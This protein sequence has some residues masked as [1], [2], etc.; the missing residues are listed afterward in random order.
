MVAGWWALWEVE[1]RSSTVLRI[2]HQYL[3]SFG[4]EFADA[5]LFLAPPV[6]V[7]GIVHML[8]Y[9][10]DRRI[11]GQRWTLRDIL[12]LTTWS[13]ASP[14]LALL[15]IAIGFAGV[16]DSRW[17]GVLWLIVGGVSAVVGTVG[18]RSAEGLKFRRV[19]SGELYKR[20]FFV[21]KE[22][23]IPLK[24]VYIVP[25]GRGQLMNAYGLSKSIAVT[26]NYGKFLRGA[27]LDFVIG[28]ELAHVKERNAWGNLMLM[29]AIFAALLLGVVL[30]SP[31]PSWLRPWLDFIII[32][33]P[34]LTFY[35][36]SRRSEYAA[37]RFAVELTH[38]P[39]AGIQA[40]C[41]LYRV[42]LAPA[43]ADWFTELFMTHPPLADRAVAIGQ[44]GNIPMNRISEIIRESRPEE[45]SG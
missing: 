33:V 35:F 40:L 9:S 2:E 7:V 4:S 44:V 25:A 38:D 43:S 37:D 39:E 28:H 13:T 8:R 29:F 5:L 1:R 32:F 41:S 27:E 10:T 45:G 36:R 30:N 31:I 17:I 18:L 14:T 24:R 21:A 12:K 11:L 22:V 19:K 42:T 16:Y 26:D 20:A 23:N 15:L 34:T 6:A 3:N